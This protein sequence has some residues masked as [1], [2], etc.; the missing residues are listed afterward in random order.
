M[1]TLQV[2]SPAAGPGAVRP[3]TRGELREVLWGADYPHAPQ[4]Q[5]TSAHG[6]Q[7]RKANSDSSRS[8]LTASLSAKEC[9]CEILLNTWLSMETESY[10]KPQ[11]KKLS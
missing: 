11:H 4:E 2:S 1:H 8:S 10:M 9:M 6:S 5:H 7:Q 3:P